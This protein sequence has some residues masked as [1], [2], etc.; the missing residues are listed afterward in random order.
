VVFGCTR[1]NILVIDSHL[2]YSKEG[3]KVSSLIAQV[4]NQDA[5]FLMF[6]SKCGYMARISDGGPTTCPKCSNSNTR[7][8]PK[9]DVSGQSLCYEDLP[10]F[11]TTKELK[12]YLRIG[13]NKAYALANTPGFPHIRI[14]KRKYF[15]KAE[16]R[17]WA[18]RELKRSRRSRAI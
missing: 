16:V 4:G 9:P 17:E 6:C 14:G 5:R 11:L 1:Y 15:P 2:A 8:V 18:E 3:V 10:D 13:Y 12:T 7:I